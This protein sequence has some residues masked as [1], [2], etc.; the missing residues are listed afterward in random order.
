MQNNQLKKVWN[1]SHN[2]II[3]KLTLHFIFKKINVKINL[4]FVYTVLIFM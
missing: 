1:L 4:Q 2:I 3:P